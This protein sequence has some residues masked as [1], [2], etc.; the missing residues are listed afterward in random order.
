MKYNQKYLN[1]LDAEKKTLTLKSPVQIENEG[2]CSS[3]LFFLFCKCKSL[4]L[5]MISSQYI[6]SRKTIFLFFLQLNWED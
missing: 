5:Y 6:L 3:I 1:I 4:T 2:N